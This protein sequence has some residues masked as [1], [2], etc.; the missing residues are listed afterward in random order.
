MW[1]LLWGIVADEVNGVVPRV[2]PH[3][4]LGTHVHGAAHSVGGCP[5]QL[6]R[7]MDGQ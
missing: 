3:V 7:G 1:I 5:D 2:S 4:H 6:S